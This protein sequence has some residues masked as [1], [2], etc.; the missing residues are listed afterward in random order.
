MRYG[1]TVSKYKAAAQVQR[2]LSDIFEQ[3]VFKYTK[4]AVVVD[5]VCTTLKPVSIH[6]WKNG[7][8]IIKKHYRAQLADNKIVCM[9]FEQ[10]NNGIL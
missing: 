7:F 5:S 2:A 6:W 10:Y 1:S 3:F 9:D 4:Q 8:S